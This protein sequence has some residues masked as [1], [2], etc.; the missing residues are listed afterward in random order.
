MAAG[1]QEDQAAWIKRVLGISISESRDAAA[2][3]ALTVAELDRFS[4][5]ITKMILSLPKTDIGSNA[6]VKPVRATLNEAN[7]LARRKDFAQAH[8]R[9]NDAETMI[10][11]GVRRQAELDASLSDET[12]APK[13]ALQKWAEARAEILASL[14]RLEGSIRAMRHPKGDK[15]VIEVMS[16]SANL[17]KEPNSKAQLNELRRYLTS[18]DVI[19]AVEA[20]N[21]FGIP[22]HIRKIL[23]PVIDLLD[24]TIAQ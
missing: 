2:A 14:K 16:I 11:E 15:A 9:L 24:Q 12:L 22:I 23:M 17:T 3:A 13:A 18:D 8:S 10:S 21:G 6:W 20:P 19:D 5:R 7:A 4:D 1:N